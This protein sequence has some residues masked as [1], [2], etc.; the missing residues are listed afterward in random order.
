VGLAKV[1]WRPAQLIQVIDDPVDEAL[2]A[3]LLDDHATQPSRD[4]GTT[5]STRCDPMNPA[6]Q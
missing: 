6:P 3:V 4:L 2:E 1:I 5:E